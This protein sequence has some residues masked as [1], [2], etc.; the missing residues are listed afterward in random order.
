MTKL[1]ISIVATSLVLLGVLYFGFE[2][3][4]PKQ[5]AVE[6]GRSLVA[7]STD[8]DV[9]LK[10]AKSKLTP[11][12]TNELVFLEE[13]AAKAKSDT[14]RVALLQRLSGRWYQLNEPAVAGYYAEKLAEEINTEDAWSIA[15]TTYSICSQRVKET[16]VNEF[17]SQQ[18]V[19][20]F[21]SAISLNPNNID[22][23]INLALCYTEKPPQDNPMKGILMLVDLNKRNPD[24]VP[25]LIQLGRLAIQTGQYEK[26]IQRLTKAVSL[27][28][29]ESRGHCLL[30]KALESNGQPEKA[31]RHKEI[32]QAGLQNRGQ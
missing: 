22:H 29:E 13:G 4:S 28:P 21:E 27:Q 6:Q 20:A 1:Q 5:A 17:C 31:V 12:I 24:N 10:D 23:R 2:I 9:I 3:K 30:A 19:K 8:I 16:K 15:G 11:E 25:V 14:A 26:A 7:K 18:A 32:C